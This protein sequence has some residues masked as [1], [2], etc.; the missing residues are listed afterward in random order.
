MDDWGNDDDDDDDGRRLNFNKSY[1]LSRIQEEEEEEAKE[2][3]FK[4]KYRCMNFF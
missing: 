2:E 4:L 1:C 3:E